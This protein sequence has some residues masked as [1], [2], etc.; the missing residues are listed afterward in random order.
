M[1]VYGVA[2][3][4]GER[5]VLENAE[6]CLVLRTA[7]LFSS[8][9]EDFVKKIRDLALKR[10]ELKVIFDQVGS[11]CYAGDFAE[12]VLELLPRIKPGTRE[13][14]HLTNEGVCSW[15]DLAYA[16]VKGFGLDCRVT[17]IHTDEFP[18]K[19]LRPKYSVLDFGLAI[20]HYSEGLS[21]CI[22]KIKGI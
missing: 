17:P 9:G 10:P 14:Y 6:T 20:R 21:D 15:Y 22:R 5:A 19:A 16:A 13:I 18:Q 4:Q 3:E 7:W 11:P 8:F 2:K 12:C 1:N